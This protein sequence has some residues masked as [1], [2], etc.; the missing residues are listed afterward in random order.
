MGKI[1]LNKTTQASDYNQFTVYE[2]N[3]VLLVNVLNGGRKIT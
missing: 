3:C 2:M 1:E